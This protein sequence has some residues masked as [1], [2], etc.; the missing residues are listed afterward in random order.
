MMN[1]SEPKFFTSELHGWKSPCNDGSGTEYDKKTGLEVLQVNSIQSLIQA[2]DYLKFKL[3]AKDESVFFRGQHSLYDT[4]LD[5]NGKYLFQPS[6]LR[7]IRKPKALQ[8][9]KK[10][11]TQNVEV[12]RKMLPRFS[13]SVKYND[14]VIEG[15]MQQYGLPTTWIDAVD[16]IWIALWFSC[17]KSDLPTNI[18]L[19]MATQKKWQERTF[20]H[21]IRRSPSSDLTE[22]SYVFVLGGNTEDMESIDLRSSVPSD[23]IRPHVQHGVLIRTAGVKGV[24][25]FQLVKGIIRIRLQDALDWLG[26]GLIFQP[27]SILPPPNYDAGFKQLLTSE[28]Q[29]AGK[30]VLRFP[31]YC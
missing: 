12:F 5:D 1:R 16:N 6:V 18:R 28:S 8:D 23:F 13:D 25:M 2:L 21:M 9:A 27:S 30:D 29:Y 15:V 17:Y 11:I 4:G 20:I 31:I 14:S 10:R 19:A 7:K 3:H 24:N 26:D 22:Y